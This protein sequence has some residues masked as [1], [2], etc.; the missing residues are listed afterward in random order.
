MANLPQI[1]PLA[2]REYPSP[3]NYFRS[4]DRQP[5]PRVISAFSGQ[6]NRAWRHVWTQTP[7][8]KDSNVICS[9]IGHF[10]AIFQ[11]CTGPWHP[12]TN[13]L[14]WSREC[15]R[16]V[17]GSEWCIN[18]PNVVVSVNPLLRMRY[19][20][21]SNFFQDGGCPPSWICDALV[22]TIHEGHLV[23][24]ITVQTLVGIDTV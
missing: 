22:W 7:T 2:G 23:V 13:R 5:R 21:F 15:V 24:F 11:V 4:V 17:S 20:D 3:Q 10:C 14:D 8:G 16:T 6:I 19:S 1:P 18:V 9:T 12:T